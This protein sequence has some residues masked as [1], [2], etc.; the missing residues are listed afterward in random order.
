MGRS[1]SKKVI[2]LAFIIFLLFPFTSFN[3]LFF[4]THKFN[5]NISRTALA[6]D[7]PD[8]DMNDLPDIDYDV[9]NELWYE[10]KVEMLII[11]PNG[12]QDF[13]NAVTPLMD[14]KNEKGVKTIILSNFSLYPGND[15]ATK[16][17]NMIK[18]FYEKENI[19]WV[20]LAGDA[21]DDL[22][23]IRKTYNPDVFDYNQLFGGS[24]YESAGIQYYKPT[25]FYYADLTGTWDDNNNNK[26][27]ESAEK[28]KDNINKDEI[29]WIPDV[30]V[31]RFP[32]NDAFELEIM[33]SKSLKYETNPE[34]GEWMNKMLLAGA[35][36]SSTPLEDE[37]VLTTYIWSNYVLNKMNFT[38]LHRTASPYNPPIPPATNRQEDLTST[39][40]ASEL[41][42]GYSTAIIASHGSSTFFEDYLGNIYTVGQATLA[43]NN[44]TPTLIYGDACTTTPYDIS[45]DNNIGEN[46]IKK[47]NAGAIGYI[48]GMRVTWYFE[49]DDELAM[50]NRGNAKLF[51]EEFF[52]QKKFQQGKALYDS[53]V[54]YME[55]DHFTE[56]WGSLDQEWERKNIL[57]YNLLGDPEVDI[58]TNK[59]LNA[60]NPFTEKV[61]EGQLIKSIIRDAN[62]SI[63]PYA[64]VHMRTN[65]GKYRTVY[66]NIKGEVNFRIPVQANE[67]YNVTITG[68]NLI[69]TYLNFTT[70]PDSIDPDFLDDKTSPKEPT[71]SSN[72]LF[73]AEVID[74]QSGIQSVYLLQSRNDD[75]DN[76]EYYEMSN[77]FKDDKEDFKCTIDKLKPGDYYFLLLAR[78]WANNVEILDD[79]SFKI[80]IPVP[81]MDYILIITSLMIVGV[82]GI[83]ALVIY[84]KNKDYFQL[85][86][87][88]EEI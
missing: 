75:F 49:D 14:W 71:V 27:G 85:I 84:K 80:S 65:G 26:W 38:H 83:S 21:Q 9:L 69:P 19:Q 79:N 30:Y 67:P 53:K 29:E 77:S 86:K 12:S 17:R 2:Y 47:E 45:D 56:G 48:G 76:Y 7:T 88:F 57:S 10:P 54:T 33:V 41:D 64:R 61:Y 60:T 59:P 50:L 16:I 13:V 66:A 74:L 62:G 55:S 40:I 58:Y 22:I 6:D 34:I 73:D 8:V 1:I 81:I 78:D 72:I 18:S 87:R 35:I 82:V 25:D 24:E 44:N 68:H 63:V 20:L 51:W 23:P 15:N 43:K 36:S 37:A 32:A 28:T 11:T 3:S 31:G 70:L 4:R 5:Y 52:E 46:L 42:L 39:N